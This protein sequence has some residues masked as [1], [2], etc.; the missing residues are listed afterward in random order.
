MEIECV[1]LLEFIEIL[2]RNPIFGLNW[3]A[4]YSYTSYY[5]FRDINGFV[6]EG[7]VMSHPIPLRVHVD[8]FICLSDGLCGW[9]QESLCLRR[10]ITD[11]SNQ[12]V[13]SRLRRF[14]TGFSSKVALS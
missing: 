7:G 4:A 2:Y 1:R 12:Y 5:A 8:G 9:F 11:G 10:V 6:P 13:Q 3:E 14:L